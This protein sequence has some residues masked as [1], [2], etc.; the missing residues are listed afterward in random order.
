MYVCMRPGLLQM[1]GR[2]TRIALRMSRNR[3]Q[4][5]RAV[6]EKSHDG[7]RRGFG[8]CKHEDMA[9]GTR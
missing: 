1:G 3:P 8:T 4:D 9:S 2:P 6:L 7:Y 5:M